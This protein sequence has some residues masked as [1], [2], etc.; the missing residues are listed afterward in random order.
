MHPQ[1]LAMRGQP[2]GGIHAVVEPLRVR[3]LRSEPVPER[4][5][6]RAEAL[7]QLPRQP[8]V[9]RDAAD[10]EPTSVQVEQTRR[11][12]L[13][14]ARDIQARRNVAAAAGHAQIADFRHPRPAGVEWRE[15]PLAL[16][17]RLL[18]RELPHLRRVRRDGRLENLDERADL[19]I[20]GRFIWQVEGRAVSG[21][22]IFRSVPNPNSFVPSALNFTVF[23][24]T[25]AKVPMKSGWMNWWSC[26]RISTGPK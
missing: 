1:L 4:E 11:R 20:H 5:D 22:G 17:P 10:D 24:S 9:R 26:A 8:V 18:R 15:E 2:A 19:R 7:R 23:P 14:I 12:H 21:P 3:M 6:A 13:G 25:L 16:L